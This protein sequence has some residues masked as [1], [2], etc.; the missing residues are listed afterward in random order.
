M[1]NVQNSFEI[2]EDD[3][4]SKESK[5]SN[6]QNY[7][8]NSINISEIENKENS[9]LKKQDLKEENNTE[10]SLYGNLEDQS[11]SQLNKEIKTKNTYKK[12]IT[13]E[14]LNNIPLP[15]FS[16]IYCSNDFISFKHLI[17]EQLSSKYYIQTSIY[18]MKILDKII[19]SHAMVDQYDK[20]SPLL[21][22][23]I[24]NT[25]NIK[26][27]YGKEEFSNFYKTEKFKSFN[28][29]N[30]LKIKTFLL[31][32]LENFI[33]RK[34]NKDLTNK[35]INGNKFPSK[36]ISYNKL[37]FHNNNSNSTVN[38][39]FYNS[40]GKIKSNNNTIGAGTCQCTGTGSYSS[41]NNIVSFSLNNN[42]NNNILC[43]NNLNMM[44]NIMEKIE[45]NEESENDEEG[46]EEFLNIFGNDT[47]IQNKKNHN[48]SFEEKYYDIW[49]PDITN[50]I[51]EKEDE[52][53]KSANNLN[54]D[55][56]GN[57][58]VD[59][60]GINYINHSN[61][62]N[63]NF[64]KIK[65]EGSNP[66]SIFSERRIYEIKNLFNYSQTS[67]L[68]NKKI[69]INIKKN[70]RNKESFEINQH[71]EIS[72]ANLSNK[73]NNKI[74]SP[75]SNEYF[76]NNLFKF[77]SFYLNKNNKNFISNNNNKNLLNLFKSKK[78]TNFEN[79]EN[80]CH[81]K[82]M[83][84]ESEKDAK[85]E[86][87]RTKNMT[88]NTFNHDSKNLLFL[89]KYPKTTS[90]SNIFNPKIMNINARSPKI[91]KKPFSSYKDSKNGKNKSNDNFVV[92]KP[93]ENLRSTTSRMKKIEKE[94]NCNYILSDFYENNIHIHNSRN[95][96]SK[97]KDIL[98]GNNY[99]NFLKSNSALMGHGHLRERSGH[100][101]CFNPQINLS[102][103]GDKNKSKE[104][105]KELF[106]NI[107]RKNNYKINI[108]DFILSNKKLKEKINAQKININNNINVRLLNK[109][110]IS[111]KRPMI[112][113]KGLIKLKI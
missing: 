4:I 24:K 67:N 51:N 74:E 17:N 50:I 99:G 11:I 8:D 43:L 41:M 110:S 100:S 52:Y 16:C 42:E 93:K 21:D 87:E 113:N 85:K 96:V 13:K 38:D 72:N 107:Y 28:Y 49:N 14:E 71:I 68:K 64:N 65:K 70:A 77:K 10:N 47:Q 7:F 45:K 54:K 3:S 6:I 31:Q 12:K 23:I 90:H 103:I 36:N 95:Y 91:T 19:Q 53:N 58:N 81:T 27:Y 34:K 35:K 20:N 106:K 69:N 60:N 92:V 84:K 86:H 25:E 61:K 76:K 111:V 82:D 55:K 46:G 75:L 80:L 29:Y 88:I 1:K 5:I 37:S 40:L 15:I 109:R 9:M 62:L 32:K 22:I 59:D 112:Q 73:N 79:R 108:N 57:K 94:K 66:Q 104:K 63:I 105:F 78:S 39:N 97:R 33:I 26:K 83:N 44:E 2:K 101:S 48:V 89:L 102:K 30:N 18:D 98:N 56:N